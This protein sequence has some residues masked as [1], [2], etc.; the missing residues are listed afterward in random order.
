VI[1]YAFGTVNRIEQLFGPQLFWLSALHVFFAALPGL[2]NS[3]V[4]GFT[5]AVV[6]ELRIFFTGVPCISRCLSKGPSSRG[7]L[8]GSGSGEARASGSVASA[9]AA[10]AGSPSGAGA[11]PA[12]LELPAGVRDSGVR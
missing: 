8:S 5:P 6:T 10:A 2:L 11:D 7:S 12:E 3:L 9:A 4:Y 1:C